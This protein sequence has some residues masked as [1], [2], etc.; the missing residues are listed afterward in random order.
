MT[1]SEAPIAIG[2]SGPAPGA[3]TVQPTVKTRKN[4]PMNST[5]YFFIFLGLG[6]EY[7][8]RGPA[9][10]RFLGCGPGGFGRRCAL[11]C[12]LRYRKGTSAATYST[13]TAP[14]WTRCRSTTRH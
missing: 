3:T 1:M 4:V 14:S 8:G 6:C 12:D 11:A 5:R 13:W 9:N 7:G 10:E 2:A